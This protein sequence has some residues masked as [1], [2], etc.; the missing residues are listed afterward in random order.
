MTVTKSDLHTAMK[1]QTTTSDWDVLVSYRTDALND[2]LSNAWKDR[3]ETKE[4]EF[5]VTQT[6]GRITYYTDFVVD[7]GGP[8]L[9]FSNNQG[10]WATLSLDVSG[11]QT[12]RE[13]PD[14]P[15]VIPAGY[16]QLMCTL[17]LTSVDGE[18]E[19]Q[20]PADGSNIYLFDKD[21]ASYYVTFDFHNEDA[22]WAVK[23]VK[24]LN[25]STL[26]LITEALDDI[27][28][29]F[30]EI[31]SKFLLSI[32]LAEVANS[33]HADVSGLLTPESFSLAC[34]DDVLCVFIHTKEGREGKKDPRFNLRSGYDYS[35]IPDGYNASVIISR[36][37]VIDKYLLPEIRNNKDALLRADDGVMEKGGVGDVGEKT[38]ALLEFRY[39]DDL[40]TNPEWDNY[41]NLQLDF[42][43]MS[44][45]LDKQPLIL[46][47]QDDSNLQ[48]KYTWKWECKGTIH[49]TEWS[50]GYP[51]DFDPDY[52]VS[53]APNSSDLTSLHDDKI[54]W[55]ISFTDSNQPD[56]TKGDQNIGVNVTLYKFDLNLPD[57]D[58]F[59]TTNIFAPGRHMIDAT[60]INFPYDLMILGNIAK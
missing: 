46:E 50:N 11:T 34:Q 19:D 58:Y 10:A 55:N 48:P 43:G 25:D 35:P 52:N 2:F 33:Q 15:I 23:E 45:D 12:F 13:D 54:S 26:D 16:Y 18:G 7:I 3:I 51:I 53:I 41:G 56:G 4:I 39:A 20:R 17:P 37:I 21:D 59:R 1:D 9:Q 38:G 36:D 28:N 8:I 5:T 57:L 27:A 49:Y 24:H 6:R 32:C 44:I 60:D 14:N 29:H 47:I 30:K 40:I 31:D 22:N 42:G